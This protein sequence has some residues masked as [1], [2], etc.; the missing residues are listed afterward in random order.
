MIVHCS[1]EM[2]VL[3]DNIAKSTIDVFRQHPTVRQDSNSGSS[4]SHR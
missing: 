3:L 1:Q 2:S 4:Q